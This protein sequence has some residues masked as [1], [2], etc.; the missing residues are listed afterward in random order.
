MSRG[1]FIPLALF[2]LS[3]TAC[4]CVT[5]P[6]N[7]SFNVSALDARRSL[8]EMRDWPRPLERPVVVLDGLGPP[9]ASWLLAGE[10]KHQTG[11]DRFVGV[12]FAFTGSFD[13]CRRRVVDAVERR[14]PCDDPF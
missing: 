6:A 4:G 8:R 11:D 12:T 1:I 10:L 14:F 3:L 13:D 2:T 9:V 5:A 7:R